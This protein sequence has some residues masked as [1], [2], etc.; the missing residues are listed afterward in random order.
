[1]RQAF[2]IGKINNATSLRGAFR[3]ALREENRRED[4]YLLSIMC[5]CVCARE[6]FFAFSC[7]EKK[8]KIFRFC[9]DEMKSGVIGRRDDKKI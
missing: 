4:I 7:G 6:D 5:A 9:L 1:M 2:R 3:I 8:W